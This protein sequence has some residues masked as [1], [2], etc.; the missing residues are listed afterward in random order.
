[1]STMVD[2]LVPDELWAIVEPLL[3]LP[4]RPGHPVVATA[5]G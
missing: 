4:P 1:M 5:L 2:D 3:P